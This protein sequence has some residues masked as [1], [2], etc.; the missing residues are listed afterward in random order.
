VCT[1]SSLKQDESDSKHVDE[2][3]PI[4][5]DVLLHADGQ[6]S[7]TEKICPTKRAKESCKP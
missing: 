7:V 4:G 2:G 3:P 1:M 6:F 5:V